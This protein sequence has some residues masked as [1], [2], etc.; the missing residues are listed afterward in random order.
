MLEFDCKDLGTQCS[1]VAKGS[2]VAEIKKLATTHAN[3]VHPEML[4]GMTPAQLVQLE[5][6]IEAKT[7]PV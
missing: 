5:Q 1:Y 2:S 7:R 4:K 6:T 3:R